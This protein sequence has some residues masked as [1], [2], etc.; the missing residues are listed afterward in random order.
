MGRPGCTSRER[1]CRRAGYLEHAN[2]KRGR[3]T[4]AARQHEPRTGLSSRRLPGARKPK[5]GSSHT[6]C[7]TARA[8]NGTATAQAASE[9]QNHLAAHE[10]PASLAGSDGLRSFDVRCKSAV[11]SPDSPRAP[12][13]AR[14]K[15]LFSRRGGESESTTPNRQNL[16][17]MAVFRAQASICRS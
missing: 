13:Q 16:P 5:T 1:G 10:N 4:L 14:C 15:A 7:T 11:F 17:A 12:E 8:E 2:R 9:R 6:G 3:A